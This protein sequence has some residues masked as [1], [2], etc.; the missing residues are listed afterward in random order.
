MGICI[1]MRYV[2]EALEQRYPERSESKTFTQWLT[3]IR[4]VPYHEF[5]QYLYVYYQNYAFLRIPEVLY[6]LAA[7]DTGYKNKQIKEWY[8]TYEPDR[9]YYTTA[10]KPKTHRR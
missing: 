9:S 5:Y 4:F 3:S 8:R 6:L 7:K 2:S 10:T 1:G